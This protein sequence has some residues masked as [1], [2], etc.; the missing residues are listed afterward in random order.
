MNTRACDHTD[1]Q[2]HVIPHLLVSY[3]SQIRTVRQGS[4]SIVRDPQT[5]FRTPLSI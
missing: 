1:S 4:M 2:V 3:V 5:T